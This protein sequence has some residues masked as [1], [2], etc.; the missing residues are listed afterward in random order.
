MTKHEAKFCTKLEKW[1]IHNLKE[2]CFIEAKISMGDEPFNFKSGFK[3]HQLNNLINIRRGP[4]VYKISDLDQMEKPL[5]MFYAYKAVSYV[6]MQWVR[7]KNKVFYL[8]EPA[9][10]VK[11]IELGKKSI[12][13]KVAMV[14]CSIRGEL[15]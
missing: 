5:D 12:D 13:E 6:A 2:T 9:E 10:I 7:P 11:L 14:V 3:P 15:K 8:I 4:F 1:L